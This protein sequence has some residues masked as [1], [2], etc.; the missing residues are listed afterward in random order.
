[1]RKKLDLNKLSFERKVRTRQRKSRRTKTEK[2]KPTFRRWVSRIPVCGN[3]LNREIEEVKSRSVFE[4]SAYYSREMTPVEIFELF[5]NKDLLEWIVRQSVLYACQKGNF[6]F[7]FSV[8]ELKV[9]IGILILS[10]Y[11]SVSRQ[12]M[13][14]EEQGDS[15]NTLIANNMRRNRFDLIMQYIHF[16]DNTKINIQDTTV[17]RYA[18]QFILEL[19]SLVTRKQYRRSHDSIFW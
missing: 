19:C 11:C 5:F 16:N 8:D 10:G 6:G 2:L 13:Y 17:L 4:E 9:F 15:H 3:K 14:W 1:M 18:T 7:E 12:R